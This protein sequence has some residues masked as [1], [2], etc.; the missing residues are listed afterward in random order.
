MKISLKIF[1]ILTLALLVFECKKKDKET[2]EPIVTT[3][4]PLAT[5]STTAI[6]TLTYISFTSGGN[7]TSEGTSAIT[8]VGIC[9][10][11]NPLPTLLKP[12]TINGAGVGTFHAKATGLLPGTKYYVRAYATNGNGTAYGNELNITTGI[13]WTLIKSGITYSTLAVSGNS[14]YG[15]STTE[16]GY[17]GDDGL[18]WTNIKNNLGLLSIYSFTVQNSK[19]YAAGNSG[20]YVSSNNGGSWSL[21]G[22]GLEEISSILFKGS[23]IFASTSIPSIVYK[24]TDNGNNWTSVSSGITSSISIGTLV[25]DGTNIFLGSGTGCYKTTDDGATWVLVNNGLPQN[26]S[27]SYAAPLFSVGTDIY[28]RAVYQPAGSNKGIFKTTNGGSSWSEIFT[29]GGS[30]WISDVKYYNNK[31][32]YSFTNNLINGMLSTGVNGGPYTPMNVGI[33][34]NTNY[35]IAIKGTDIFILGGGNIYKYAR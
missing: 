19:L 12:H 16:I 7:I 5:I 33:N 34:V 8:A 26:G 21:L 15:F 20:I 9:W 29:T 17:S 31:I 13:D 30:S 32:Y 28:L 24:S 2:P 25:S 22:L 14:L 23:N 1:A 27:Y 3:P 6:D 18:T 11:I 10:D 35:N 4:S